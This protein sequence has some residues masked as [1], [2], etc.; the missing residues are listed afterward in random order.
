MSNDVNL[1]D[2]IIRENIEKSSNRGTKVYKY[3]I[4]ICILLLGGS[5]VINY[6]QDPEFFI[7]P[8]ILSAIF[9]VPVMIFAIISQ[10]KSKKYSSAFETH[11][12]YITL[13]K[14]FNLND[15][16]D[17]DALDSKITKEYKDKV[18]FEDKRLNLTATDS[19]II[20][21]KLTGLN[22]SVY[23]ASKLLLVEFKPK[24]IAESLVLLAFRKRKLNYLVL[25]FEDDV[26][27]IE[28]LS[29]KNGKE[30]SN[31]FATTYKVLSGIDANIQGF[32]NTDRAK[33][34]EMCR[35]EAEKVYGKVN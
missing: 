3:M 12:I 8:T 20:N 26:L 15:I 22:F 30:L 23:D 18:L 2:G 29:K 5:L 16:N 1:R 21:G 33:F 35:G 9:I 34:I 31:K 25:Y 27:G 14:R 17:F 19:Y 4:I 11:P 10:G 28:V 6:M 13:K 24:K 7:R 32:Y